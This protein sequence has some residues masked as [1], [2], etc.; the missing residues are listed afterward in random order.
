MSRRSWTRWLRARRWLGAVA[1]FAL[2]WQAVL[3]GFAEAQERVSCC[4]KA[5]G[6]KNCMCRS[7]T[8]ERDEASGQLRLEQCPESHDEVVLE[9]VDLSLP[10][11]PVALPAPLPRRTRPFA[12]LDTPPPWPAADVV[13]PPPLA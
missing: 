11:L 4:C 2:S 12:E 6:M 9:A 13:T 7:C 10:A 8:H 3:P 1:A 5:K